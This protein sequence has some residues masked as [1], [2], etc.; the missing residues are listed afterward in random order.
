MWSLTTVEWAP[1][2]GRLFILGGVKAEII[3]LHVRN[4][5]EGSLSEGVK[6]VYQTR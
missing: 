6:R 3:S 1:P 2:K 4:T 5:V